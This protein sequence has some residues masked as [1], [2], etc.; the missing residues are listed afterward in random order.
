[1]MLKLVLM[2]SHGQKSCIACYFDN[3]D[4]TIGMVAL[5][6]WLA[7]DDMTLAWIVS[8][9]K[10]GYV[11][12]CFSFCLFTILQG[13]FLKKKKTTNFDLEDKLLPVSKMASSGLKKMLDV[14]IVYTLQ[15]VSENVCP[16]ILFSTPKPIFC[17]MM[18][19]DMPMQ[20]L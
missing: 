3:L 6:T 7:S 5:M 17:H 2:P 18:A 15:S 9:D 12:G 4:L 16:V 1:M 8:C 11:Y 19:C 14:I 10:K 20:M 13:Y